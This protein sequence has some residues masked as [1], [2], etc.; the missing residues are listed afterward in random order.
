MKQMLS[1][2]LISVQ[3]KFGDSFQM[4]PIFSPWMSTNNKPVI[5]DTDYGTWRRIYLIPFLNKFDDS[6]KDVNMPKKLALEKPQI[7]GWMIE[8]ALKVYQNNYQLIKPKC[9]EVALSD[10]KSEFDSLNVFLSDR[11]VNFP[12]KTIPAAILFEKYK[13]WA[14]QNEEY[15]YSESAFRREMQKHGYKVVKDLN[16]GLLYQGLKLIEDK[17]GIIFGE[18]EG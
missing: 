2:E 16:E 4:V 12:G 14:K 1:G 7:L 9:L 5:R 3:K 8:G 17:H 6:K 11:C 13:N 18:I 10:Y 15:L